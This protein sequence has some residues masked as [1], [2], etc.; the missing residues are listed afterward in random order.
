MK[1]KLSAAL[2]G[3]SID[4]KNKPIEEKISLKTEIKLEYGV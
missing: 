2:S 1:D 3:L 4:T